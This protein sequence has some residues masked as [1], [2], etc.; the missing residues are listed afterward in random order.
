M[1]PRGRL[2]IAGHG[3]GGADR[4]FGRAQ[5]I[6]AP[7]AVLALL[8]DDEQRL[9]RRRAAAGGIDRHPSG[10]PAV[11]HAD[12]VANGQHGDA[13]PRGPTQHRRALPEQPLHAVGG[14]ES[15]QAGNVAGG[16]A[17][18]PRPDHL[19]DRDPF[20]GR[21]GI[22]ARILGSRV[23]H[24]RLPQDGDKVAGPYWRHRAVGPRG[25]GW[26]RGGRR[27]PRADDSR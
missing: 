19:T 7:D 24:H 23:C 21:D 15:Q 27:L 9:G 1:R 17:E 14:E 11:A 20:P 10:D 8:D 12:D 18:L 6:D 25:G 5:V 13:Q 22:T 4:T 3:A 26:R 2:R 16:K